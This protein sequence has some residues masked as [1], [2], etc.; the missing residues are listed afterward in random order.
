[1][2]GIGIPSL[3]EIFE[4]QGERDT[5]LSLFGVLLSLQR[6]IPSQHKREFAFSPDLVFYLW[7]PL[8][9]K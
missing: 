9:K 6:S 3:G 5:W 2:K 4:T 1:M 8:S 7:Y